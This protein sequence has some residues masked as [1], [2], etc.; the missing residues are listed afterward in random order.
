V[1]V[2]C[3]ANFRVSSFMAVYGE[4]RLGWSRDQADRHARAFW[5]PSRVWQRFVAD[6][7]ARWLK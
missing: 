1:F 2:H 7:R 3:A 6:A 4:M 5:E